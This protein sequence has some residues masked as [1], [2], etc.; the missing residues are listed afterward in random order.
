M[1][2]P[3][4]EVITSY[5]TE[6]GFASGTVAEQRA[7][8]AR[9][10]GSP[11]PP[12]G[13][14]LEPIVLAGRNA[15]RLTPDAPGPRV[16]G[17]T[18]LYLHGGGYCTGTLDSHRGLAGRLAVAAGCPVVTVDYRLAPEHPY[19]AGLEDALAAY[20]ELLAGGLRPELTAIAGDS[21]GGGLTMATLVSLRDAGDPLPAA[22]ALLSPWVDLTQ[23]AP[24]FDTVVPDDPMITKAGLDLYAE[25]YL[26]DLDPT[27]PLASPLFVEDLR[28]LPPVLVEVGA[29]EALLDD[30]TRLADRLRQAGVEVTLTVWPELI[31]VFQAFPGD[32]IPEADQSIEAIAAF[33]GRHLSAGSSGRMPAR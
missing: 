13:V 24:S 20:R 8:M 21:A 32:V 23:S 16:D 15:E 31:H 11:P 30:S 28:G 14:T 22:A 3:G 7:A 4:V 2:H 6:S 27:F 17:G 25:S 1:G 19:P 10:I 9:M 29:R 12:E 26:G 18:L 5:L 33:V